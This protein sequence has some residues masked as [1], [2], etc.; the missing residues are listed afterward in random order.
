MSKSNPPPKP[1]Q[2]PMSRQDAARIQSAEARQGDGGVK[3]GDFAARAQ[4][5]ADRNKK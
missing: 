1:P 3:K 2:Q 5:A 4:A